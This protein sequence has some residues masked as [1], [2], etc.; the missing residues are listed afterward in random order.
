MS[1]AHNNSCLDITKAARYY[2]DIGFYS[3]VC[4]VLIAKYNVLDHGDTAFRKSQF[5]TSYHWAVKTLR[6]KYEDMLTTKKLKERG[7]E[8]A[9]HN[10]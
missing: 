8:S 3:G 7:H 2:L 6:G 1:D 9:F 10:G 5:T 4:A